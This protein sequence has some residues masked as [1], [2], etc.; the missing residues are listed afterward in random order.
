MITRTSLTSVAVQGVTGVWGSNDSFT[1]SLTLFS[2]VTKEAPDVS[3][4]FQGPIARPKVFWH[5]E[6]PDFENFEVLGEALAQSP[7]LFRQPG[8]DGGLFLV[9][10]DGSSRSIL[11]GR[12]LAS[13][14][15]DRIDLHRFHNGKPKSCSISNGML[16][17]ML[18]A[19]VFLSEFRLIDRVASQPEYLPGFIL[20]NPGYND[21]GDGHRCFFVGDSPESSD[22]MQRINTFLD[23]MDF[24]T[25]SDRANA[26]AGL[27][28]VALRHHWPGGKP[29]ILATASKS[30]SGKD[31]VLDFIAGQTPKTSVS[32]EPADWAT[33][34]AITI[35]LNTDPSLGMIR[36]ENARVSGSS[37]IASAFV[38][39]FVTNPAPSL[40][41][42]GC[43]AEP[44]RIRN[45]IVMAISTN[46]GVLS[47][48]L[49]NRG[50]PIHLEPKGSITDRQSPIGSPQ[51][52]YLPRYREEIAAEVHGMIERW[53]VAGMP[54]DYSRKH[55]RRVWA[56]HIGGIL[57]VNGV[58]GFLDNYGDRRV[59]DDPIRSS[60]AVLGSHSL[61]KW[62]PISEIVVE[63]DRLGLM[64]P[65]VPK[66]ERSRFEAQKR[67]LGKVLSVHA[68]ENFT[69]QS[70]DERVDFRLE[71][72]RRRFEQGKPETRYG[73]VVANKA[74]P[75]EVDG[76]EDLTEHVIDREIPRIT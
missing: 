45:D 5:D 46:F 11:K 10:P 42:P 12:P 8:Y 43:G 32:W 27:L 34:K 54:L 67:G 2:K 28:T 69:V 62:L 74:E 68:N 63:V 60:I 40:Y 26:V 17:V 44:R 22:S 57:M 66:H 61:G 48:D 35:E 30:H 19:E 20:T 33:Q 41:S 15:A 70:E 31:T 71:K 23:V 72:Q 18:H 1:E 75:D 50:L 65:L 52:E 37:K 38:E 3:K 59:A 36:L 55:S 56:H 64:D 76:P 73:F 13:V 9:L 39:R 16:E 21:G 29:I 24:Q 51:E 4:V 25:H 7:D 58:E 14:I 49:L 53:R 6:S 47:E